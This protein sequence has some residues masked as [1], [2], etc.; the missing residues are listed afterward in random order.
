METEE[1]LIV[2][3]VA[4]SE[5]MIINQNLIFTTTITYKQ[6]NKLIQNHSNTL[7]DC[8]SSG[9]KFACSCRVNLVFRA[10]ENEGLP[11]QDCSQTFSM[12][13]HS[14]F[15]VKNFFFSKF[16]VRKLVPCRPRDE[17]HLKGDA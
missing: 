5:F 9:A 2:V 17:T 12:N 1:A 6:T 16:K 14:K 15:K 7:L 11:R 3:L 13:F 4:L 10:N 8:G